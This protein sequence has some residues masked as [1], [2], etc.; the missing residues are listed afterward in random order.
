MVGKAEDE[1][2]PFGVQG[3][4]GALRGCMSQLEGPLTGSNWNNLNIKIMTVKD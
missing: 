1:L 2:G 4:K 3:S